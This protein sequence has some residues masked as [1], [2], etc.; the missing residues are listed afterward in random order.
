MLHDLLGLEDRRKPKFVKR[1]ANM[2]DDVRKAISAYRGEVE[3][4]SFP[5]SDH[6]FEPETETDK[7]KI[8]ANLKLMRS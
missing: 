4:G 2:A 8:K 6:I 3:Q 1:F 5:D 7:K